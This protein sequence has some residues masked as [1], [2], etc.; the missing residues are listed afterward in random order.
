MLSGKVDL[1]K[2]YVWYLKEEKTGGNRII[3]IN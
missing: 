3:E 2:G 1:K